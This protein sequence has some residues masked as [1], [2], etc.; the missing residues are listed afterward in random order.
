MRQA[1]VEFMLA[2]M[3]VRLI[4]AATMAAAS[5]SSAQAQDYPARPAE[6]HREARAPVQI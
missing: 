5:V 4:F 1:G 2:E 6:F 3:R